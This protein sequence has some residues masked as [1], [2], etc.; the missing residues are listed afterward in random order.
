VAQ[1]AIYAKDI[2]H[3]VKAL[4]DLRKREEELKVKTHDLEM[5]NAAL[6]ILLKKRE[7]DKAELEEKV[8]ANMKQLVEPYLEELKKTG[9]N[10]AQQ[11]CLSILA[12][13]LKEI[14]A[15][16]SLNLSSKYL[17]FS[18]T[19]IRIANLVKQGRTTNEMADLMNVSSRTIAFHRENIRKKLGISKNKSNLRSHIL[20]RL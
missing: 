18:P 7:E 1:L 19:E 10:K 2:S 4:D 17:N 3:E 12:Q 13:N 15:P 9:P 11:T 8:L 6:T 20:T 5:T 16:F 14:I